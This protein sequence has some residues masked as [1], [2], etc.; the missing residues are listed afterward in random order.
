MRVFAQ[1][2]RARSADWRASRS[3]EQYVEDCRR[4]TERVKAT[5]YTESKRAGDARR[6]ARKSNAPTVEKFTRTEVFERDAWRCGICRRKVDS[7]LAYP[8]PLSPSL[9]HIVPLS[10]GGEHTKANTR[11][12]HLRCNVIR[13]DQG[14]P[15]QLALVG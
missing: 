5:G 9:D 13:R 7:K 8:H 12:A 2:Q 14:A 4:A 1:V 3:P 6:R 11:L 10:K 15:E